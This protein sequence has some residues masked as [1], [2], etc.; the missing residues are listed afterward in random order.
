VPQDEAEAVEWYRKAAEQ[1][2]AIAQ[3]NLGWC[4]DAGCGT[5]GAALCRRTKKKRPNGIEERP[6]R[7]MKGPAKH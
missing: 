6:R 7:G 1:G 3:A 4:Y 5:N 2:Y